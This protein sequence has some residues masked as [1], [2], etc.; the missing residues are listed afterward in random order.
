M[1][2]TIHFEGKLKSQQDYDSLLELTHRFIE[3]QNWPWKP[4]QEELTT[5]SRF[6]EDEDRDYVGPTKG[7]EMQ[8]HAD[9][10]ALRLEFDQDLFVQHFCKTQFAPI[11]VHVKVV[12]LLYILKPLFE[13]LDVEDEG[14][15]FESGDLSLLASLRGD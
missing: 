4:I 7:I 13:F 14:E 6:Y 8:P 11:E 10:E 12:E 3:D 2:V 5:L 15:Y 9:S 1:G